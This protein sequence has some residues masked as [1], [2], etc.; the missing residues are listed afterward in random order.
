[1]RSLNF[2]LVAVAML[3]MMLCPYTKVEESFNLQAI[4]DVLY[5][6][7]DL[8]M[9]HVQLFLTSTNYYALNSA[10]LH[11]APVLKLSLLLQLYLICYEGKHLH[12]TSSKY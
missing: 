6:G 9:V 2:V 7:T 8:D 3:H 11:N 12:R 1:M 10:N 4:H 5:H